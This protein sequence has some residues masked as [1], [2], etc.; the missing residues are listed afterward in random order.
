[1]LFRSH[2]D[3]ASTNMIDLFIFLNL[4][5][6]NIG[7]SVAHNPGSSNFWGYILNGVQVT[8][9]QMTST[10]PPA[11]PI[12]SF[13]GSVVDGFSTT[14]TPVLYWSSPFV[15]VRIVL[16]VFAVILGLEI[17]RGTFAIIRIIAKIKQIIPVAG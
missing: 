11:L 7:T 5:A 13:F 1:M 2:L 12:A 6:S 15:D 10:F 17:L 14:M 4:L 3:G 9:T 8:I 16:S